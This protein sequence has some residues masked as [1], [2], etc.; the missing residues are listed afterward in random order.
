MEAYLGAILAI[1]LLMHIVFFIAVKIRR[2]DM[3]DAIWGPGFLVTAAGAFLGESFNRTDFQWG[4]RQILLLLCLSVWA[5]RL[6]FHLGL[7]TLKRK[8]EDIRYRNW[9][10]EWGAGWIL[11]SYLQVFLLQGLCMFVI[12][13]PV[14]EL[15][16][17]SPT[18]VDFSV[19]L[20]TGIWF[21]GFIF[22]AVSDYQLQAFSA[23]PKNKGLIMKQGLWSWSRHP[24]YFGEVVQWWG[25]YVMVITLSSAW[26]TVLSPLAITFLILKVS[27]VPMLEKLMRS[28]PGY[29]DYEQKTSIFIPWPPAK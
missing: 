27:G 6:F 16:H 23:Q 7:R 2:N 21:F 1:L 3:I 4:P 8:D 12:S 22:E 5:F 14:I 19:Y 26:F 11:R 24:N 28:R 20:G 13:L 25:F 17:L 15:I 29:K 9:R 18:D 10:K